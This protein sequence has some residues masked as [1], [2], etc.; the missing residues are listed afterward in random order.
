MPNETSGLRPLI[1]N[2]YALVDAGDTSAALEMFADDAK[3]TFANNEPVYGRA[4][5]KATFQH[6]LDVIDAQ[7]H[8]VLN[9]WEADEPD[10]NRSIVFEFRIRFDLKSGRTIS[11]GGC[12][13]A[14]VNPEGKFVEQRLYGDLSEVFAGRARQALCASAAGPPAPRRN[15]RRIAEARPAVRSSLAIATASS[16]ATPLKR[17]GIQVGAPASWRPFTP[18]AST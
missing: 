9:T 17:S 11:K 10:G 1:R 15:A 13:V 16:S 8:D 5:A 3:L 14:I 6:V 4:A 12:G 2:Y 18:V 7:A